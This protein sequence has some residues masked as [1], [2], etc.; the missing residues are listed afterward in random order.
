MAAR[1]VTELCEGDTIVPLYYACA[2][3]SDDEYYYYGDEYVFD[4]EPEIYF[5]ILFDGDYFYS[6]YIDDI[7]GDYYVTDYVNFIVDDGEVYF[8]EE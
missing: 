4:G 3:D 6:F 5:D 1:N 8:T 7:F 2:I